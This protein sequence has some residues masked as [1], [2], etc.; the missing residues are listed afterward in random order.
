MG[1]KIVITLVAVIVAWYVF[2]G[3]DQQQP[4]Q[5]VS[6]VTQQKPSVQMQHPAPVP[7]QQT[8]P[9]ISMEN[10]PFSG[11]EEDV[12]LLDSDL[13]RKN[14]LL[15]FDGSGSMNEK[16]CSGILTK[17]EAA[18]EAVK[19]WS[20]SVAEDANLGLIVFDEQGLSLR[21]PLGVN[22]RDMFRQQIQAV[23]PNYKTPLTASL[24]HAY[25]LLTAQALRQLGYGE[26][27]IVVVTDGAANDRNTLARSVTR[28]L[29]ESPVII[30]TIGFCIAA[31]HSL[32][33]PGKTI[34]TAANDP[35]ALRKGLQAV[36]AE[37]ESF[38]VSAF[39]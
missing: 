38:D 23:V 27:T 25:Q 1:K 9:V 22:N 2:S 13:N 10:W 28:I 8:D 39:Q 12:P 7:Q 35:A 18:K 37:S 24:D 6:P 36:L 21:L 17:A 33:Q 4:S 20:V 14:F 29:S 30:N 19:E 26:Y 32:N 11:K 5:H 15:I 3:D 31:D 34:Y 16:K